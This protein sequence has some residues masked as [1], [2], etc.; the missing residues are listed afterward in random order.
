MNGYAGKLIRVDLSKSRILKEPLP[1]KLVE[2]Y[3]GGEALACRILCDEVSP[4]ADPAGPENKLIIMTGPLTGT[5]IPG[6]VKYCLVTKNIINGFPAESDAS[7]S[8]GRL[9]KFAGYDGIIIEG[10]ANSLSY[11]YI[12]DG[13]VELRDAADLSGKDIYETVD[14]LQEKHGASAVVGCIGPAGE[15]L[16][17]FAGYIAEKEHSAS[18]GGMGAVLGY[19]KLKAIVV[20]SDNRN[21]AVHDSSELAKVISQWKKV[22]DKL[23]LGI[24]VSRRGM[25]GGY[26]LNYERGI[27]PVKNLTV[28]DWEGYSGLTYENVSRCFEIYK[29]ACP[30]CS[31]NH[32]NRF[33]YNGEDL[34]EPSFDTLTGY[35]PNIGFS[36]PVQVVRLITLVDRMGLESQETSWLL[37]FLME[38]VQDGLIA[39]GELDGLTLNWGEYEAT[40]QLIRKIAYR[41]GC[42]AWLAEGIYK[43]A[44]KLGNKAL[45]KAVYSKNGF[46]PQLM[47]NRNDWPFAL[48]EAF[49][50]VG[51]FQGAHDPEG[52]VPVEQLAQR[53]A[54]GGPN[55]Q[56]R[57]SL[58]TC[59]LHGGTNDN[60]LLIRALNAVT[61][62]GYNMQQL[63][64]MG[65]KSITEMRMYAI[66]CG[67]KKEHDS[68]SP[69][70]LSAPMRGI[71]RGQALGDY[72]PGIRQEYYRLMGWDEEGV[73]LPDTLRKLVIKS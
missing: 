19:K 2:E 31:F 37:S 61:G 3:I 66:K 40:S 52:K 58:G 29:N 49:S 10:K 23:G 67:H 45:E 21:L 32:F 15:N 20:K 47:D 48:G 46:V 7:G 63:M 18:K 50:N 6:A 11:L 54:A 8:F 71:R 5:E 25:R 26:E 57:N 70:F 27:V 72:F 1:R 36:D 65:L 69:R 42:G 43:S 44:Q 12:E 41:E 73:P 53:Q 56:A 39:P 68:L 38:C 55:A 34:K 33:I 9:L 30:T 22:S 51:H 35:G 28:N 13:R 59:Y 4:A 64:N 62:L 17:K 60:E 14:S 16:V 24:R